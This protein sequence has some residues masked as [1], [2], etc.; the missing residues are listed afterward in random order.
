M[1]E[2]DS[3]AVWRWLAGLG[4]CCCAGTASAA[5]DSDWS[6]GVFV[7]QAVKGNLSDILPR[8]FTGKL[9]F[10]TAYASGVLLRYELAKPGWLS[11]WS[12]RHGWPLSSSLE[13]GALQMSGLTHN[14]ELDLDWRPAITFWQPGRFQ[15]ET[16]W[17]IG[18]SHS[19]GKPWSDYEDPEHP[20]GYKTLFHMTP[21]L[22][23]RNEDLPGWSL[24]LRLHHRSGIYG[25][26]AP[27]KVGSNHVGL[28]LMRQF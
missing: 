22:A 9:D 3:T 15:I 21:E 13:F 24:G 5:G 27:R 1:A 25:T 28:V 18:L 2:R 11:D 6:A 17:G 23:L 14:T 19:F 16:A 26:V 20:Q 10:Q 8:A 12:Q 7:G 4:M